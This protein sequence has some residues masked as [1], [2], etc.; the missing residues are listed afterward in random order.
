MDECF[1]DIVAAGKSSRLF[2]AELVSRREVMD[3]LWRR[4]V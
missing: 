3:A 2:F 1:E 4:G